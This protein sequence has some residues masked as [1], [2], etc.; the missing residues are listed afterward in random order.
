MAKIIDKIAGYSEMTADEKLKAI[1][2]LEESQSDL[3]GFIEKKQFDR[4]A[5]DLA[6]LKK[7]LKEKMSEAELAEAERATKEA[8]IIEELENL[9]KEK[10]ISETTARFL[11]LGY[12][13]K[14][15]KETAEAF[16]SGE[17]DKVF[18]NQQQFL[19]TQRK[20]WE[21]EMLNKT[22]APPA[23][24]PERP[25]TKEDFAKMGLAE[26][27]KLASNDPTLYAELTGGN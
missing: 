13:E 27:Q 16:I 1:E 9:R 14:L 12:G 11:G 21:T 4:V 8:G 18:A 10:S 5:S 2:E 22:P 3:T 17:N 25:T 23:G 7:Q 15:A 24:K 20:T 19:E 26:K 6:S